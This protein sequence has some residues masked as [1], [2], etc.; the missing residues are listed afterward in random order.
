MADFVWCKKEQ[1]RLPSFR[2][3]LCT[4]PCDSADRTG[5]AADSLIDGLK[6]SGRYKERYVMKR[7]ETPVSTNPE[8]RAI[9]SQLTL[10]D[11]AMFEA[12]KEPE[13]ERKIFLLEDGKLLP[14]AASDY[15]QSLLYEVTESFSVE[16]RLVRPE[17][18]DNLIY[19]GKKPSKKTVPV[20]IAKGGDYRLMGS[21]DELEAHPE[22]LV[23]AVEVIGAV[24]VKQVFVLKRK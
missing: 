17:D 2:C 14:F 9:P 6:R 20:I 15:S 8:E 18:P 10:K 16:C 12:E 11:G 19:E 1:C 3:V 7:K 23:E 13:S 21:W 24:P 4:E 5:A 22:H